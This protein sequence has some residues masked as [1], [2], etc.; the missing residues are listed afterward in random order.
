MYRV[1]TTQCLVLFYDC[2]LVRNTD[3]VSVK[4]GYACVMKC[5]IK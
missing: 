5:I 3:S 2:L 1:F 4:C